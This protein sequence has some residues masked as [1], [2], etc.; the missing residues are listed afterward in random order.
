LLKERGLA[1]GLAL[2]LVACLG[3]AS[4]MWAWVLNFDPGFDFGAPT[5]SGG[6][7]L[8]SGI[9]VLL[10]DGLRLDASRKM[11]TL[12][13]LRGRGADIEAEVGTPSFSRPGRATLVVGAP[14]E[15]HGV[16][17]NRQKREL[18]I[19][20]LFRRVGE[21]DGTCRV[22]GSAIWPGL[23]ARDISKCGVFRPGESKEGP[24][25]F[26]RQVGDVRIAQ[27][28]GVNFVLEQ[29]ALLRIADILSTDFAAHEY[30]G[31]SSQ[32]EAE[33]Q[34]ADSLLAGIVARLDLA[35]ETVVVVADHGHRDEGGHGGD[36]ASVLAIPI[37]MA[38]AGVKP[39]TVARARQWDVAPT[40]A[41]LL[42]VP[43]PAGALGRPL[44]SI[45]DLEQGE[46]VAWTAAWEAQQGNFRR[47]AAA[48]FGV[49]GTEAGADFPGLRRDYLEARKSRRL[50]AALL[51]GFGLA[52]VVVLGIRG[53]RPDGLAAWSGFLA[54]VLLTIGPVRCLLPPLSFSAINYDELLIP[55]F[56]RI[57]EIAAVAAFLSLSLAFAV[58]RFRSARGHPNS[59]SAAVGAVALASCAFLLEAGLAAWAGQGLLLPAALPAPG[60]L[61][62]TFALLLGGASVAAVGLVGVGLAALASPRVV[63]GNPAAREPSPDSGR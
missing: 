50:P 12:N 44:L 63:P 61:V 24:G 28:K 52:G 5:G 57:V 34:R 40:L 53:G 6:R 41:A 21:L 55:Y 11:P 3:F 29:P 26:E 25:A 35:R 45:L 4:Q 27:E 46:S 32:Y 17:T 58:S 19:D 59:A 31:R 38:G 36:E 60:R 9:T 1:A 37:V 47:A 43:F 20:N 10:I 30:G 51:L 14:P 8:T 18:A 2:C 42:G 48:R 15:I 39:A 49:S 22:A 23:F 62:E 13:A 54:A 56:L 16:T 7:P 33:V